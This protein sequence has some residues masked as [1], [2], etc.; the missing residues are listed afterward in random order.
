MEA[1]N[2][3]L[4]LSK[5][6]EEE[7]AKAE[8]RDEEQEREF[9]AQ[10]IQYDYLRAYLSLCVEVQVDSAAADL[11]LDLEGVQEIVNKYR[12]YPVKRWNRLFKDMRVYVDA[13]QKS[14]IDA[15][16][17]EAAGADALTASAAAA[18]DASNDDAESATI[19]RIKEVPVTV[20]FKIGSDSQI[21]I[22]HSGVD[23]VTVEYYVIDAET[24][25]S[26]SPLTFSEHSQIETQTASNNVSASGESGRSMF[27]TSAV[28]SNSYRLLKPNGTDKHSVQQ[29]AH[30]QDTPLIIPILEKYRNTNVMVSVSTSPPTA[31]RTWKAYYSQTIAVQCHER[32]GT[33]KI[34]TK[35]DIQN[36]VRSRAIR[37][38]YVKVYAEMKHGS[39]NT[40]FWKDGYTDLIG[41]F[42]YA[43]VSTGAMDAE[44][45]YSAVGRANGLSDVK[46]FVVFVDGGKEG[47]AVK[48]VPVPPV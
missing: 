14:A 9:N 23:E 47:C 22:R 34:T 25:F 48:T 19:K 28:A 13:I 40:A 35:A 8:A 45:S 36:K 5:L 10:Q 2:H 30:S 16:A 31:T 24:M 44:S 18:Q 29:R 6:V 7:Q 46:R 20:D 3:F 27:A 43:A 4:T 26:N 37:G 41:Q 15:T 1:K 12:N 33:I 11:E 17:E 42:A 39:Q 32:S 38:A 21:E